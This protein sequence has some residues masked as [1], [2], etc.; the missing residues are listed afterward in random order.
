[1]KDMAGEPVVHVIYEIDRAGFA[2]GPLA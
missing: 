2:S 1:V